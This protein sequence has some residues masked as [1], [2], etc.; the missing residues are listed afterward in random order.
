MREWLESIAQGRGVFA[1][2]AE[3]WGATPTAANSRVSQPALRL[4]TLKGETGVEQGQASKMITHEIKAPED[5]A[6][7]CESGEVGSPIP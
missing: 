1:S 4:F 3:A 7:S 2:H 5:R 6:E